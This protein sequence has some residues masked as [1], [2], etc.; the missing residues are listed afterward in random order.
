MP[1]RRVPTVSISVGILVNERKKVLIT[2]RAETGL[3]GGL[4]EFPGGKVE[5]GESPEE[6]CLREIMEETG[7]RGRIHMLL[8]TIRHAYTHF[9]LIASVFL[10]Q[11]MS[12]EIRLNG[13]V[14][15]RWVTLSEMDSY[16]MPKATHKM[17]DLLKEHTILSAFPFSITGETTGNQR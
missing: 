13:P 10:V 9:K 6:A 17:I 15:T 4:W 14:D 16:P 3:L 12:C 8:G 5:P 1:A 11:P 7:L 2:R